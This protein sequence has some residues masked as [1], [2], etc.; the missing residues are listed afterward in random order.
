MKL[1]VIIPAYNEANRISKPLL[2]TAKYLTNTFPDFEI[3]VSNDGSTDNTLEVVQELSKTI[4]ELRLI[5]Y[6][7]N[8]GKGY[9]IKQGIE[10]ATG[11]ILLFADADGAT[12]IEQTEQ[13]IAPILNGKADISIGTRY[14]ENSEIVKKQPTYRVV[15]SRLSNKVIQSLLLPGIKDPHCGFKAFKRDVAKDIFSKSNI[16]GWSFDLE[17]LALAQK[18][19]YSITEIPVQWIHDEES[20]GRLRHLPQ[21]IKSVIQIKK[22]IG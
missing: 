19:N 9:A 12:P 8:K 3:I 11:D 4:S 5:S 15:W 14:D 18:A 6:D 16:N 2:E 20:K 13:L 22:M 7:Q 17:I 1:S 21:E 10:A